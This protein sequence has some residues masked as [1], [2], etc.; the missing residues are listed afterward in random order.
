MPR[1][2]STTARGYGHDHQQARA[3]LAPLVAAGGAV[4]ARCGYPIAAG[5]PWDL[6]HTLDR[7]GYTGPE[8]RRCNRRDGGKRGNRARLAR[9]RSTSLEWGGMPRRKTREAE[10]RADF[11]TLGRLLAGAEGSGAAAIARER[12]LIGAEL[13]RLETPGK[14]P[15]VDELA[16]RRRSATTAARPPARRRKPG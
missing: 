12:R 11:E 8:H 3:K 6:G 15:L 1:S 10:L 7:Q 16:E 9:R 4:C 13:E 5:A 2:G 14:V